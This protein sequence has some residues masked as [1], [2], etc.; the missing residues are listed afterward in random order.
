[1]RDAYH[2]ATLIERCARATGRAVSTTSRLATGDGRTHARLVAGADITTRRAGRVVQWLSDHWPAGTEWPADI[3]R[4]TPTPTPSAEPAASLKAKE[5]RNVN[6][7]S[8]SSPS[9]GSALG[10]GVPAD[11]VAAVV[12][13]RERVTDLTGESPVDWSA[14][15]RL[16][17]EMLAVALRLRPDGRIA[18]PAALCAALLSDRH[19]YDDVVRRYAHAEPGHGPRPRKGSRCEQMLRA[20]VESGDTRFTA[21]RPRRRAAA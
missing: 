2:I 18:S 12:A 3:P 16:Q 10:V 13:L 11:P 8:D 14:V 15:E 6:L 21:A 9:A 5:T 19:V 17:G 1:M 20:L 7:S 4:P